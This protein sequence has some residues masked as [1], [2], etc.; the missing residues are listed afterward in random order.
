MENKEQKRAYKEV[1]IILKEL[2]LK[3]EV[4]IEIVEMMEEEQDLSWNFNFNPDLPLEGQH[5][6]KESNKL[7]L[8]LYLTYICK[9]EDKKK[10]I[11]KTLKETEKNRQSIYSDDIFKDKI[12]SQKSQRECKVICVK[13]DTIWDKIKNFFKKFLFKK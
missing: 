7:L 12:K 4:P 2:N 9:N 3:K 1:L 10:E 8:V 5:I 6:L 11:I 13:K